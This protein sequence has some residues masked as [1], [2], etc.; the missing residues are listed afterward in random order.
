MKKLSVLFTLLFVL[1]LAVSAMGD[2]F[3]RGEIDKDKEISVSEDVSI[4]K[5]IE[6]DVGV[7]RDLAK[8]AEAD[9]VVNQLNAFNWACE[10]CAEKEALLIGSIIGNAG[11]VSTNQATGNMNNQGNVVSMAVDK[12][13]PKPPD[14]G[15]DGGGPTPGDEASGGLS[16]AQSSV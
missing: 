6:I 8:A 13:G 16:H 2:V 4:S 3:V 11:I 15:G 1:G 12:G 10:N 5:D 14:N 9:T 7:D